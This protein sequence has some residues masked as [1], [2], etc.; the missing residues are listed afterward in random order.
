MSDLP[1]KNAGSVEVT[2][3]QEQLL[4]NGA[5]LWPWEYVGQADEVP[6]PAT[7]AALNAAKDEELFWDVGTHSILDTHQI[8]DSDRDDF[9]TIRPLTELESR[10]LFGSTQPI[11]TDLDRAQQAG[12]LEAALGD[13]WTG[14][15]AVLYRD[16]AAAE[17]YFW[18]CSGD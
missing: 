2:A 1:A 15:Y 9:G 10:D 14:R 11:A 17:I 12:R 3:I 18:G 6:R 5:Y 4:A 13:R 8:R 7:L 16:G